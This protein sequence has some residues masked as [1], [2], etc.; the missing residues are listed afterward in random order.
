[1][2]HKSLFILLIT[3]LLLTGCTANTSSTATLMEQELFKIGEQS[4]SVKMAVPLITGQIDLFEESYG[5]NIWSQQA[6]GGEF[7]AYFYSKLKSRIALVYVGGAFAENKKYSLDADELQK[8]NAAA[9]EFYNAL[10][11][12]QLSML[13]LTLEDAQKMYK[14]YRCAIN[15]F[16]I[17]IDSEGIE[18]S[19]DEARII[20]LMQIRIKKSSGDEVERQ[21]VYEHA[22]AV[23]TSVAEGADFYSTAVKESSSEVVEL[24]VSRGE[25]SAVEEKV[26]FELAAGQVSELFETSDDY[27]IYKCI[28][29]IDRDLTEIKSQILL[30]DKISEAYN[31]N[32]K[33]FLASNPLTWNDE[34]WGEL[35]TN[36]QNIRLSSNFYRVYKQHFTE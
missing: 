36:I 18:I 23:A 12:A 17:V 32:I 33:V 29:P 22:L 13:N 21:A 20:T 15:G 10:S 16:N 5:E 4:I 9:D 7:V 1:M 26:A 8:T 25:L 30:E 27:V 19:Q 14:S 35:T 24:S 2:K 34:A 31:S 11:P 6:I 3:A 28:S